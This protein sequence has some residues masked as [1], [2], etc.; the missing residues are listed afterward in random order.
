MKVFKITSVVL[1]ITLITWGCNQSGEKE[2][3][4]KRQDSKPA[5]VQQTSP[6]GDVDQY[7]RKPGDQHYG[8]DHDINSHQPATQLNTPSAIPP[9][10]EPDKYGR[11]P[12]DA[13]YG[14][15]HE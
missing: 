3:K 8:H 15:D 1:I 12:G 9:T 6:T 11:K 13:H 10:G 7:G 2:S 14:H 4:G 5:Q